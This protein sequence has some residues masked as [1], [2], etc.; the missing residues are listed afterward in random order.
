MLRAESQVNFI[1]NVEGRDLTSGTCDVVVCDGFVGNIVLKMM[2]GVT[3]GLF[4]QIG[5][6]V[7]KFDPALLP[8]FKQAIKP[9]VDGY[10]WQEYGGAPLLG[11]GGI[12]LICHGAS[13]PRAIRSTIRAGKKMVAAQLNPM[14]VQKIDRSAPVA[15]D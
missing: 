13:G 2:E 6:A 5:A 4:K 10:D 14:I 9:V 15:A 12:A 7:H 3:S 1:G 11:V 8:P